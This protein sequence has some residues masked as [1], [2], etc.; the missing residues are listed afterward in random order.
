M[1]ETDLD[2]LSERE[3]DALTWRHFFMRPGDRPLDSEGYWSARMGVRMVYPHYT[4]EVSAVSRIESELTRR[5]L[6]QAYT[7]NLQLLAT[8]T[9]TSARDPNGQNTLAVRRLA[10]LKTVN[11]NGDTSNKGR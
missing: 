1:S 3:L 6:T 2:Q 5:G 8:N 11:E 10:A 9:S 4:S 7:E